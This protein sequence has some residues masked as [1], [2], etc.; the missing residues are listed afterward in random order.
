MNRTKLTAGF[1]ASAVVLLAGIGVGSATAAPKPTVDPQAP[2]II[3]LPFMGTPVTLTVTTGPGGNIVSADIGTPDAFATGTVSPNKVK[4]VSTDGALQVSVKSKGN[5]QRVTARAGDLASFI[6][7]GTWSGD[8]F[9]DAGVSSVAYT[10]G[11][12]GSGN[13]TLSN[14]VASPA[15]GITTDPVTPEMSTGEEGASARAN[16]VFTKDGQSR[17]LTIKVSVH[18]GEGD[19]DD[20]GGASL[21]VSLGK[22]RGVP[23]DATLAAGDKTWTGAL[24]DGVTTATVLYTVNAD[25]TL[26]FTSVDPGDA[27]VQQDANKLDIRFTS[28]ERVRISAKL[29]DGKITV[30][31]REKIRCRDAVD[32]TTNVTNT[33]PNNGEDDDEGDDHG[34]DHHG[35]GQQGGGQ[36]GGGDHGGGDHGG[37]DHGGDDHGGGQDD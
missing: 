6:G 8:V 33:I 26:T 37:G 13:P 20:D 11:D 9:G 3:T 4:F 10:V 28:G 34:G 32:P 21:R 24:C 16:V 36:Q 30:S 15:A 1:F 14:V 12:D 5:E 23:V 27:Q 22:L 29:A 17:T 31:I 18:T 7:D 19:D 2:T 35:G 25:G